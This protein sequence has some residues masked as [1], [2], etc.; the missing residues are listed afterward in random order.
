MLD[1]DLC[2][3]VLHFLS[4]FIVG[5]GRR[6]LLKLLWH[7]C[8]FIFGGLRGSITLSLLVLDPHVVLQLVA[9][10]DTQHIAVSFTINRSQN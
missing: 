3:L 2:R 4:G 1:S 6:Y 7:V 8:R 5:S 10:A 9:S